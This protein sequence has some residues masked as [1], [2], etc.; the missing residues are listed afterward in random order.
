[1]RTVVWG[2]QAIA[3]LFMLAFLTSCQGFVGSQAQVTV[4]P[5]GSGLGTVTSSPAG[6]NCGTTCT[7]TIASIATITLTATPATGY[8]FSG[9]SGA[10]SGTG[11]CTITSTTANA[12][13]FAVTARFSATLQSI[14]HI[15]FLAQENRSFDSYFGALRE[16]WAQHGYSDEDFDGLPQFNSPAGSAPS[17]PGCNPADPYNPTANP[18]QLS[19]CVFDPASPVTSFHYQTMCVE[20][21]SPSWN[22]SHVDWDFNDATGQSAAALNG[23]V[24]TAGHDARNIVPPFNDT[25]GL[26]AMG[27]YNG[28][29]LDYY[30]FMASNFATS[31]RWFAPAM[32]RTPPN[33]EYLIAGTSHGYAYQRNT[34][35]NDAALIPSPV[36]FQKL[37]DAG[38]TWKIY[39]HADANNCSTAKCLFDQSYVKDFTY[40]TTILNQF[41]QNL[42]STDQFMAEA[43][44]G[45][46]PQ[47]A[48]IEPASVV[49]LDEHPSDFDVNPP[50]CRVQDGAGFVANLINSVMGGPNWK[51]T[52]FILTF[53]EPGGFY[54]H[55]SPQPSVSPDGIKPVDLMPGDVCTQTTGPTCDFTYTGYRVPL[56]V[57]SPF[58]KK[59]YVSHTVTDATAILK[60]IE[61]RFGVAPLTKR[62][63][64]QIDMTEFLDFVNEPWKMPPQP[65]AQ[66]TTGPCYLD[67]LP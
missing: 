18:P 60:L 14:N 36:I 31:D 44:S 55:V 8:V 63:A 22:E 48:Q 49:G 66:I 58:S 50:C 30:Y 61:T 15:I 33:R 62:D 57:I 54:D 11:T 1:M 40:G 12:S 6:I 17:I 24:W 52:I 25:N 41:P 20:N 56:I 67:R 46:L 29:D 23:F 47:V 4:T 5:A 53:D 13:N 35:A 19:D 34:N 38:I 45:N 42:E 43:K 32:T 7:A 65:P 10:C 39:A 21:P 51:D 16:Y 64:A 28:D 37:Q 2:I 27:Y 3:L 26:R 9:W 59:H